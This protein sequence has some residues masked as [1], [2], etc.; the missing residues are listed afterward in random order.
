MVQFIGMKVGTEKS[1]TDR[2]RI[3]FKSTEYHIFEKIRN[4][5]KNMGKM[6]KTKTKM[7]GSIS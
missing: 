3:P 1:R 4:L 7:V 2:H 6:V 5:E